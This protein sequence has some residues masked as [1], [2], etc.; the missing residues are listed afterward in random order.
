M[1]YI[2]SQ[3]RLHNKRLLAAR[4]IYC[5]DDAACACQRRY[6]ENYLLLSDLVIYRCLFESESIRNLMRKSTADGLL[7][8]NVYAPF[9]PYIFYAYSVFLFFC[10]KKVAFVSGAWLSGR[11]I[12]TCYMIER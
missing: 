8:Y 3:N 2:R 11:F 7:L 10:H 12:W 1:L 6:E 5:N 4:T 9:H